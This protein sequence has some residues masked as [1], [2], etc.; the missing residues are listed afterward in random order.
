LGSSAKVAIDV[1]GNDV[2]ACFIPNLVTPNGDGD[3]DSFYIPC[4]DSYPE[5]ELTVYNRLGSQVYN[6][7]NYKND[8]QGTYNGELLPAGTYY[9]TYKLKPADSTCQIGYLT[10]IRE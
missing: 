7:R 2:N 6:T 4:A 5:S 1:N 10:I 9:Y 8:W 3:N